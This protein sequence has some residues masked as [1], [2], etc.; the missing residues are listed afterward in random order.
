LIARRVAAAG[1][2]DKDA[3]Y[4]CGIL[5]DIG[6]VA[7]AVIQPKEYSNLLAKHEGSPQSILESERQLFGWDHCETGQRMIGDWKLPE[8]FDAVVSEHHETIG[9]DGGWGMGELVKVSCRM[10]DVL[11]FP[12]FQGCEKAEFAALIEELPQRERSRFCMDRITLAA[13]I[14][15]G[16]HAI[17]A[18]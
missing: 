13:E 3:A 1:F 12:A 4:T 17:E 9:G 11:G 15:E 7:L 10:A 2:L 8:D 16:I 6:R 5:H 18:V 14:A